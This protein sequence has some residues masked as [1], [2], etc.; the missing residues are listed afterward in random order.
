MRGVP[1]ARRVIQDFKPDVLFFTGGFVGVPVAL[2]GW[3]LPKVVFV[4]DIEPALALKWICRIAD[5]IAVTTEISRK[6]YSADKRLVVSG[7]PTRPEFQGR[8]RQLAR[9]RLE[10][11]LERPVVMVFGGS[12]GARSINQALWMC[13]PPLLETAQVIHI[14]GELDWPQVNAEQNKLPPNRRGDY[15][16]FAYLHEE[17]GDAFAAAD[18][19]VS[20]AGAAILGEYPT[21][22]LPSV[23]VP[24][25]H[26]WRYQK[27]N[28]EYL[29]E[30]GAAV[31]LADEELD[32]NLLPTILG[33]LNDSERRESMA[34]A[35][36][37]LATP[38]A[39][40][41][42]AQEIEQLVSLRGGAGA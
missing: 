42:I 6:Y 8:S 12:R 38:E 37:R 2:A 14:T 39:A 28:S 26:A 16:A 9:S 22:N 20:R 24:Y 31:A 3:R 23:L 17:M 18:L 35:A 30:H 15:R 25:P 21:F 40:Q 19:V 7:Y 4:P 10:L 11:D 27:V 5:V 33:L 41:V 1:S 13:L 32:E 29:V 34:K 36:G